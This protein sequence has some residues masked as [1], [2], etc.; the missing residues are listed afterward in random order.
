L[1]QRLLEINFEEAG[2]DALVAVV[3]G[4]IDSSNA[5]DLRLSV[6]D[7][8]ATSVTVLVLDLTDVTYLDS[9]G[10]ESVFELA[11]RLAERRQ[12]LRLVAPVGS[13]TRRVLELCAVGGVAEL[14]SSRA[15][16]LADMPGV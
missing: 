5:N 9:S 8:L 6:A 12:E 14:L 13:G 2:E 7:R 1:R 11:R 16:S 15:D 4:E 10:V 3:S